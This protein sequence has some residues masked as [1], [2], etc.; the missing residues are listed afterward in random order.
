MSQAEFHRRYEACRTGEK[1]ELVE[2]TVYLVSPLRLPHGLHHLELSGLFFLY[3]AATP[4]VQ[5]ADNTTVIL[6]EH[7]EPQPDLFLRV[8]PEA[9]GR[10]RNNAES[11]V[12]GPPELVVEVAHASRAIDLHAKRRIYQKAGVLEYL[13]L[14]IDEGRLVWI[15]MP[16]DVERPLDADGLFRSGVFPGLWIDP[17]AVIA[18]DT[19]RSIAALQRGLASP[20]HQAFAAELARKLQQSAG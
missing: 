10:S 13:V 11:Y 17:A 8:A 6:S 9:G 5:A 20:E 3:K 14:V 2:G 15:D 1:W 18:C 16:Q 12:V 19:N 4:G 7:S